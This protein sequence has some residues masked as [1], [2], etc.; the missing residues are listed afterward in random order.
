MSRP[1][2]DDVV[3]LEHEGKP[4]RAIVEKVEADPTSPMFSL[5]TLALAIDAPPIGKGD[6]LKWIEPKG[7][8]VTVSLALRDV[9]P[10]IVLL[11]I[12]A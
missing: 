11:W 10:K 7:R 6:A 1:R 9:M 12:D 2:P 5:V 4:F 8:S 3:E